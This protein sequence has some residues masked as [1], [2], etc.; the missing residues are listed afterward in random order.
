MVWSKVAPAKTASNPGK[1]AANPGKT[2][3]LLLCF[4][5]QTCLLYLSYENRSCFTY[6][7]PA[8]FSYENGC[9]LHICTF[10]MKL[11]LLPTLGL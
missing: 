8:P 11:Y 9:F 6:G 10:H 3:S 7:S 2:A 5:M 4:H 1:T